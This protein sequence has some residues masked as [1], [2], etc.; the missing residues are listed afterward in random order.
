MIDLAFA[1]PADRPLRVLA[2]GAHADDIEIGAGGLVLSVCAA[3]PV[4]VDW[5]VFT[6]E[7]ERRAEAQASAEAFTANAVARR[8]E[9]FDLPGARLPAVWGELKTLVDERRDRRPDLVL[10]HRRADRHQDHALV[11]E[12]TWN[13]FRDHLVLEYEIPKYEGDLGQPDLFVPLGEEV[14]ETKIA[15]LE[16]HFPSQRHRSWFDA[17]TFRGLAR[18]RGVECNSPTRWAEAFHAP[19]V[20]LDPMCPADGSPLPTGLKGRQS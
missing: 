20:R 12:L 6:A 9:I 15:L 5:V 3:R 8:V 16:H 13:S 1:L 2:F 7:G 19:K 10:T 11:G 18:L 17:D 4:S 14:L